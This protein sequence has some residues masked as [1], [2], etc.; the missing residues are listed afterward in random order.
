MHSFY[1]RE[2]A[3]S[4]RHHRGL[5][6]TAI[7]SLTAALTLSGMLLLLSHNAR[8]ALH[9]MGDRREM[10]VYLRDDVT[11]SQR[12]LLIGRLSELYGQASFVSKDEAWEDFSQQIGDP[13]LLDAVDQ[14]PL[15]SSLRIRLK[16]ELLNPQSMKEAA[17]Q[18]GQFPEVEGVRYGPEWVQRLDQLNRTLQRTTIVV[19]LVAAIAIVLILANTLRFTVIAR[20][21]QVEVMSRLGASDR[22][23]A[24]PFVLEAMFEALV[25]ALFALGVIFALQQALS[26][27]IIGVVFL[28]PIWILMFLSVAVGLAWLASWW[29]LSRTLRAVGP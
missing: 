25:A 28:P 16:P 22:F 21:H 17:D 23:I 11:P 15:P 24:T 8:V 18:I 9:L 3:R 7:F 26:A 5:G 13:E 19:G 4:F 27:R 1:F 29:A 20:R 10:V 2:A 12:D 6:Y 14:N